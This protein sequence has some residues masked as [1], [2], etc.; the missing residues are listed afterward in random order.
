MNS[1]PVVFALWG[2]LGISLAV[3]SSLCL[4]V[5]PVVPALCLGSLVGFLCYFFL[6]QG[7]QDSRAEGSLLGWKVSVNGAVVIV[8][9]STALLWLAFN[10][11]RFCGLTFTVV[12]RANE[13][14]IAAQTP[15]PVG[16]VIGYVEG[17][18]LK[19]SIG[20]LIGRDYFNPVLSD[21]R[22]SVSCY[23]VLKCAEDAGFFIKVLPAENVK[24]GV[25]QICSDLDIGG[26]SVELE[27][28]IFSTPGMR[29]M[30][31]SLVRGSA[32]QQSSYLV[33]TTSNTRN[34]GACI[35]QAELFSAA[36]SS[37]SDKP[38]RIYGLVSRKEFSKI[39]PGIAARTAVVIKATGLYSEIQEQG[40]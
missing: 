30:L 36:S 28:M 40:R 31:T 3:A 18:T 16:G 17:P 33:A 24:D 11:G 10:A 13:S 19:K 15:S 9:V 38:V 34:S 12:T 8:G 21:L 25:L 37:S 7:Q 39:A 14:K 4:P 32:I 22:R 6:G 5:D 29:T 26:D 23:G 2:V 1:K 27:E 35:D 20:K